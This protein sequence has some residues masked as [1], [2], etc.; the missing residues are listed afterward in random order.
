MRNYAI[1]EIVWQVASKDE[2]LEAYFDQTRVRICEH[3][4]S[5]PLIS[6]TKS[7]NFVFLFDLSQRAALE[8]RTRARAPARPSKPRGKRR[9]T[10]IKRARLATL[11]HSE[12]IEVGVVFSKYMVDWLSQGGRWNDIETFVATHAARADFAR[13][14]SALGIDVEERPPPAAVEHTPITTLRIVHG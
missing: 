5:V 1:S 2:Q 8:R 13:A 11:S 7:R 14:L 10:W 9:D 3:R 4:S 12:S 6:H